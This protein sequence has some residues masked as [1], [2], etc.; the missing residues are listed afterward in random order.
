MVDAIAKLREQN[1]SQAK[2]L[3]ELHASIRLLNEAAVW[4]KIEI[5]SLY[6]E[7]KRAAAP[8]APAKPS[9]P[10]RALGESHQDIGLI[11]R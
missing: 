5:A 4:M 9:F 7:M 3:R 8:P 10:A 6:V 11:T 2:E 1:E